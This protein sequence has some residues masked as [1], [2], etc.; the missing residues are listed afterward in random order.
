MPLSLKLKEKQVQNIIFHSYLT[1][2]I[3]SVPNT[4]SVCGWESDIL[5]VNYTRYLNEYEIKVNYNDFKN[6]AL[7]YKHIYYKD[8]GRYTPKD[9]M[10]MPNRFWYVIHSFSVE[11][12]EIPPYAGLIYVYDEFNSEIIK[13]APLLHKTKVTADFIE[14]MTRSQNKK[15]WKQRDNKN[16][17][18]RRH[19]AKSILKEYNFEQIRN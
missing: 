14:K 16:M 3:I 1:N 9:Y 2:H 5:S 4:M 7:K 8:E 15:F 12:A 6:D 18:V 13:K 17:Y 11:I 10:M 19:G